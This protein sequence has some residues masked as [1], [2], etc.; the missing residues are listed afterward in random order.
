MSSKEAG[1][2]WTAMNRIEKAR[3]AFGHM[4]QFFVFWFTIF[5][6]LLTDNNL[7]LLDRKFFQRVVFPLVYYTKIWRRLSK[8]ERKRFSP[9]L[10]RL[11][12]QFDC[13]DKGTVE[14][15]QALMRLGKELAERFQRSSSSVEGRNGVLS[16]LLHRYHQ[17]D[18]QSLK[19]LTIVHNFG[20][21]RKGDGSTAAERF[22]QAKHPSLFEYLVE[23]VRIPSKPQKQCRI[24]NRLMAA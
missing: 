2:G 19:A 6:A 5:I 17:L 3:R 18:E 8:E 23:N 10:Q 1:L 24:K 13:W 16:L 4:S 21:R 9:I 11:Q 22:F 15:K 7:S 20:S 14:A 12:K